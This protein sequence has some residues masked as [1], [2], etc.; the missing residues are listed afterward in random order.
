MNRIPYS[1]KSCSERFASFLSGLGS[2]INVKQCCKSYYLGGFPKTGADGL[3][4]IV[5]RDKLLQVFFHVNTLMQHIDAHAVTALN[6]DPEEEK[7]LKDSQAGTITQEIANKLIIHK[8][9]KYINSDNVNYNM[10]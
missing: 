7:I 3:Y 2:L 5:W 4:G 10:E 6:K 1:V 8:I 9:R